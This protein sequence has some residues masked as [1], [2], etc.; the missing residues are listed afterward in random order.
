[1]PDAPAGFFAITILSRCVRQ[2]KVAVDRWRIEKVVSCEA[3]KKA[4]RILNLKFVPINSYLH[5][6]LGSIR[7]MQITLDRASQH[8][9]GGAPPDIGV[10][11][12]L[13]DAPR[14]LQFDDEAER[15]RD[16]FEPRDVRIGE[17][18]RRV[19]LKG[20]P[21]DLIGRA[22]HR[23]RD[24]VGRA[25]FLIPFEHGEIERTLRL[26]QP[27]AEPRRWRAGAETS[28]LTLLASSRACSS[29][30]NFSTTCSITSGL[31]GANSMI[32]ERRLRNSGAN[33]RS[34]T[35]LGEPI[36]TAAPKPI[37]A[38]S[39][40]CAPALVVITIMTLRKSAL[41]R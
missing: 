14:G 9:R 31:S 11:H 20:D 34:I 19:R 8:G 15:L 23:N 5:G 1:M 28:S 35:A 29:P 36:E 7:P 2:K 16:F 10:E 4:A 3:T 38:P 27:S 13:G 32:P 26:L 22:R 41:R 17:S 6:C 25:R 39:S 37:I 12:A 33:I 18:T 40:S 30:R 24:V 21:V